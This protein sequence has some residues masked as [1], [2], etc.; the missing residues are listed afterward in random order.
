MTLGFMLILLVFA[1][2]ADRCTNRAV[3]Q[4]KNEEENRRAAQKA[5]LRW[6]VKQYGTKQVIEAAYGEKKSPIRD[7]EVAEV[8]EAFSNILQCDDLK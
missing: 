1:Y 6:I 7:V 5:R 2:A 8:Q 3:E 4:D